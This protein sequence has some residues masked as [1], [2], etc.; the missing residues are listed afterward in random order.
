M[1]P[2]F[3]GEGDL[4]SPENLA[5]A[6][7]V[8]GQQTDQSTPTGSQDEASRRRSHFA[9]DPAEGESE[10]DEDEEDVEPRSPQPQHN[11]RESDRNRPTE[12][13]DRRR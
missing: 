7:R 13:G 1:D 6:A 10:S 11:R 2:E 3:D 12:P 4:D 9:D 5:D 8:R